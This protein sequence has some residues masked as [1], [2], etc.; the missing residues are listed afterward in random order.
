MKKKLLLTLVLAIAFCLAFAITSLATYYVDHSGNLVESDSEDIAYEYELKN[1]TI[2]YIYLHDETVREIIVPDMPEI[3]GNVKIQRDWNV[4]VGIY[5]LS[6]KATKENNLTPEITSLRIYESV[7]FDGAGSFGDVFQEFASLEVIHCYANAT[8]S[9]LAF[10]GAPNFDE[11]HF[12]GKDINPSKLI[13]N[14]PN[15]NMTIVFHEEAT[16]TLNT[17]EQTIPTFGTLTNW[18]I[19]INPNILPSNPDDPRLGTNWGSVTTTTGWELIV[20]VP[21]KNA[22][23][24]AQLE[25]LANNHGFASR[26]NTIELVNPL[27]ATVATYCELG[28]AEHNNTSVYDYANGYTLAGTCTVGCTNGCGPTTTT[29]LAPIFAFLG[30]AAKQG[31]DSICVGYTVNIEALEFYQEKSNKTFDYGVVAIVP[32]NESEYSP[33]YVENGEVKAIAYSISASVSQTY[34]SSFEFKISKI[35]PSN[36][37]TEIVMCGYVYDGESIGYLCK[38]ENEQGELVFGQYAKASCTT[39]NENAV[40]A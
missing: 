1:N 35:G 40:E 36:Y 22:Y 31:G 7:S 12:Y 29:E 18:K 8:C 25:A 32:E 13:S 5:L 27:V 9:S 38:A 10:K 24:A 3:T 6:D 20:A 26:Y 33:L 28:Y 23:T 30:Y 11:I 21:N 16:G 14:L 37:D 17:G 15:K 34:C 19:I 2:N 4:S 39:Y